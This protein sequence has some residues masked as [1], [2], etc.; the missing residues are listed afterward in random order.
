MCVCVLC[1]TTNDACRYNDSTVYHE[2]LIWDSLLGEGWGDR[3]IL[4][5]MHSEQYAPTHIVL[6][7]V[8]FL[9]YCYYTK[10]VCLNYLLYLAICNYRG[11]CES[12]M[13]VLLCVC[14]CVCVWCAFPGT[15]NILEVGLRPFTKVICVVHNMSEGFQH[16]PVLRK[17]VWGHT[18]V[19]WAGRGAWQG[20][21]A[22]PGHGT[23][24]EEGAFN[25]AAHIFLI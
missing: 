24:K 12:W 8:P 15:H 22:S 18:S 25:D 16:L 23:Q 1:W 9:L 19:R 2:T 20:T 5:H 4:A 10:C 21:G 6:L 7:I 11:S 3:L 14:V 13:S 17:C